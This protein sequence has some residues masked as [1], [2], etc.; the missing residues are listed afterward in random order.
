[1]FFQ[2]SETI[3]GDYPDLLETVQ[4]VDAQL[5]GITSPAPLRPADISSLLGA[6][7]NQVVSV[8]EL[9]AKKGVLFD[10]EMVDCERCENLMSA[11]EFR[12]AIEDE[13]DFECTGCSRIFP[14]NSESILI[15]RMTAE[16]LSR[17]K[18][19]ALL[20]DARNSEK[21]KSVSNDEPLGERA[22]VVLIAMLELGAID[23]DSRK[24]TEDIAGRALGHQADA[25]S[26]KNVISELNTRRLIKTKMGRGGGCWLTESGHLRA[27]KLRPA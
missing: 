24:S 12:Q 18:A 9:L 4:Q 25:N 15:Y 7:E 21:S 5:S 23:S 17:T 22:Q 3:A 20:R 19:E 2:E 26:L 16:A 13:D 14:T 8:F 11:N 10:E 6:E 27:Q 1:M